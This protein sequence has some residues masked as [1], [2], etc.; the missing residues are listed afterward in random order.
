MSKCK[1]ET[2]TQT[3]LM[4]RFGIFGD[5]FWELHKA[6]VGGTRF[7]FWSIVIDSSTSENEPR[8]L[9]NFT[10]DRFGMQMT[11]NFEEDAAPTILPVEYRNIIIAL[12]IPAIAGWIYKK[13][14]IFFRNRRNE[15]FHR[16]SRII[17]S[18]D[19][20]YSIQSNKDEHE[21]NLKQIRTQINNLYGNG[22]I[23][24]LDYSVLIR[25]LMESES[26]LD[27]A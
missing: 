26:R 23:G 5:F 27:K 20:T 15:Y 14:D 19:H 22:M 17:D 4:E 18:A 2:D 8:N 24:E 11:A 7:I 25:K 3:T 6:F 12:A 13:R 1:A 9:L 21:E 10:A 16:Y